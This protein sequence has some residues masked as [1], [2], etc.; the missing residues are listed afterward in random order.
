MDISVL[1]VGKTELYMI[2]KVS[3]TLNAV[4]YIISGQPSC[5]LDLRE[6]VKEMK[7]YWKAYI[8]IMQPLQVQIVSLL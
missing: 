2:Q 6:L 5:N 4:H 8:F 1:C 3:L 7:T